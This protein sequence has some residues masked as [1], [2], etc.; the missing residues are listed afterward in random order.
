MS[1]FQ[2]TVLYKSTDMVMRSR[3]FEKLCLGVVSRQSVP[4]LKSQL[5]RD[6]QLARRETEFGYEVVKLSSGKERGLE[7]T[8]VDIG[9]VR[10]IDT[11]RQSHLMRIVVCSV[12]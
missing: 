3:D 7:V 11:S 6:K 10:Y 12:E 8:D 9:I 5:L 4:V 1:Q 2:K